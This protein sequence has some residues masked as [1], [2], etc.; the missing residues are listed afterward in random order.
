M[1]DPLPT[2]SVMAPNPASSEE[3]YTP[4][5]IYRIMITAVDF[6]Y[7]V[8]VGCKKFAISKTE[9]LV[10]LLTDYLSNPLETHQKYF[11]GE[12]LKKS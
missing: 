9:L 8:E 2:N 7:V 6:G 5:T 4:D 3:L 12:I 11:N 10:S 1:S